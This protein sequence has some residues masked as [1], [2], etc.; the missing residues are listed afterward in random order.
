[1]LLA[2]EGL[3]AEGIAAAVGK[4]LLTVRRF[5]AKGVDFLKDATRPSRVKP[6]TSPLMALNRPI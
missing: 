5:G 2:N 6:L 4:S 1:V 3:T